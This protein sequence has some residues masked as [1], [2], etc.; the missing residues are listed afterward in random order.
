MAR[1]MA[2]RRRNAT[3]A[4]MA[5]STI[6]VA[7]FLAA[8]SLPLCF[9]LTVGMLP[10]GAAF[11]FDRHP[12]RYLSMAV[13]MANLAGLVWPVTALLRSSLSFGG[14]LHILGEPR[15]WLIMYGAAAIGWA[16]SEA[17]PM[18]ARLLLDFGANA[19]ER[20]LRKRAAQ[21]VEEWGGEVGGG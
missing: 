6:V 18:A 12:R 17:A 2:K 1:R 9:V 20:K 5:T 8:V 13:G 15:N 7:T 3:G 16:L 4:R 11:L 10:T 19:A 21:L 14:V